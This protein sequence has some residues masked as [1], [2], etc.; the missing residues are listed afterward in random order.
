MRRVKNVQYPAIVPGSAAGEVT[1]R[2]TFPFRHLHHSFTIAVPQSL[3]E[4]ARSSGKAAHVPAGIGDA[5]LA[6]YYTA[7]TSDPALVP[8]YRILLSELRKI[9]SSQNY[10]D[11]AYLELIAAFVQSIPYDTEKVAAIDR[12]PRFPVET[13]VDRKGI[14][15][16]KS[17]LLAGLLAHEGYAAAVLHFSPE[18]HLAVGIPVPE[19]YDFHGCGCAVIE[20]TALGFVG[21]AEGA[22][23]AGDGKVRTLA[24]R[25]KVFFVGHGSKR[26]GSIAEVS[27]IL[28]VRSALREKLAEEGSFVHDI[29]SEEEIIFR[30]KAEL[31][32]S[33]NRLEELEAETATIS[34]D[35]DTFAAAY[36]V[37]RKAVADHNAGVSLLTRRI[38]R[39][40]QL[41]DEYNRLAAI[42]TFLQHNRLDRPAVFARI[43]NLRI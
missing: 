21:D 30:S 17:L 2:L 41:V 35:T 28:L 3:Y 22:F 38:Q 27:K 33:R 36:A 13:V 18:N 31:A 15:S 8:L 16:D 23:P 6:G 29:R 5:W 25:P 11:D 42:L 40:N 14:C 43:R 39:Y 37:Y 9:R 10:D 4:G 7:F 19:G 20:S 26:Y 1:V 12:A 24:S 34:G 32:A